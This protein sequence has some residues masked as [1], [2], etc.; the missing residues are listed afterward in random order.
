MSQMEEKLG[1]TPY[2]GTLNITLDEENIERRKLLEKAKSYQICP[3]EGY[4]AG[5][6]FKATIDK[7]ECAIVL[8]QVKGYPKNLLEVV[9]P[10]YLRRALC[11]KDNNRI[12]VTV[13]L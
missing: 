10:I 11:L 5:L 8:P 12:A 7:L 6:V 3:A 4:C 9:A 13:S 1:Y 2:L